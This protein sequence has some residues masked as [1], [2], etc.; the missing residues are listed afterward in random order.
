MMI[1]SGSKLAVAGV[2]FGLFGVGAGL[3][4][5]QLVRSNRGAVIA[6]LPLVSEQTVPVSPGE[7]VVSVEVPR[8]TT[9]YRQWEIEV[10]EAKSKRTHVMKYS[11]PRATGAV[12]GL[13]TIK[14]PLGRVTLAQP[15]H[16]TLRVKGLVSDANYAAYHV[17]L[18]R[19]HLA[20]MALQIVALVGCGVGLLLSLIWAMWLL[21]IVKTPR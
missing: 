20:R 18:A 3:M 15:D 12:K 13:S 9:E 2:A 7:I 19:P 8:L 5:L 6:T 16:L 21:G 14:I 11:G 1:K 17:V 4:A 10:L